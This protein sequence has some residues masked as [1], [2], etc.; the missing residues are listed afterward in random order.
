M[1]FDRLFSRFDK[2]AG[3]YRLEVEPENE[4]AYILYKKLGFREL[5]Y[6]QM[7]REMNS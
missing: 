2:E 5:G 3:R 4:G 7:I 1:F 6:T